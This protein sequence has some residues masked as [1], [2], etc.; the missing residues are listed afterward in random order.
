MDFYTGPNADAI[1]DFYATSTM[2][3]TTLPNPNII[4]YND[5]IL[6]IPLQNRI[7]TDIYII[8]ELNIFRMKNANTILNNY[9][10]PNTR[11]LAQ[12]RSAGSFGSIC[13]H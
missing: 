1:T 8:S 12:I 4:P 7:M 5:S 6:V 11:K 10:I 3:K 2:N 9:I 13:F